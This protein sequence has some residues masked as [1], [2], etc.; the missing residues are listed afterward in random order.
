MKETAP[1]I[2]REKEA[3]KDEPETNRERERDLKRGREIIG[4]RKR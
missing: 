2:K 4:D 3:R 1:Q